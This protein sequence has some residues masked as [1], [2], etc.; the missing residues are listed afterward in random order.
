MI[1]EEEKA[2]AAEHQK[3]IEAEQERRKNILDER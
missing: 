2:L 1:K 3:Y